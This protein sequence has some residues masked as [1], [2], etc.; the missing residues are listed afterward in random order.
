[1]ESVLKTTVPRIVDVNIQKNLVGSAMAGSIG[2]FNAHSSN[3]VTALYLACGQ[4]LIAR[5]NQ[6]T[7]KK[8][9]KKMNL[10]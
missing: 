2:G 10:I 1:M 9:E 7:K 3:L 8:R 6:Y 5:G 4:V